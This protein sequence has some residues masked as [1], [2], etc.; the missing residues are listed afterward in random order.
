MTEE[1]HR[2]Q[3][4]LGKA[5]AW[6]I[7]IQKGSVCWGIPGQIPLAQTRGHDK[8]DY[9]A[10][11]RDGD[12]L[13]AML[14]NTTWPGHSSNSGMDVLLLLRHV[15]AGSLCMGGMNTGLLDCRTDLQ[16][17]YRKC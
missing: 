3:F 4:V 16:Q 2:N 7:Y 15:R 5:R 1:S 9:T 13:L 14:P 17:G 11:A 6:S 8:T 12:N 10:C